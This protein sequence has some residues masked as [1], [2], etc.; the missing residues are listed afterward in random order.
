MPANIRF[1]NPTTVALAI[2]LLSVL[3]GRLAVAADPPTM[4]HGPMLGRPTSHSMAVWARTSQPG[5]FDVRFGTSADRLDQVVTAQATTRASDQTGWVT[6]SDLSPATRYWYQVYVAGRPQGH[7]GTF[8]TLPSAD[9]SKSCPRSSA[10]GR[11]ISSTSAGACRTR[12]WHRNVP[13]YFTFDDHELVNDI[14]GSGEAGKRHRRTRLSRHRHLCLARLPRLGEPDG[15]RPPDSFR[16]RAKL[17]AGSDLLVDPNTDFTKLPLAEMTNLHVHWG[18]PE[19]GV[20][21]IKYDN[22]AGNKNSYVYDIKE[23][24]DAA[25]PSPAHARPRPMMR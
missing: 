1:P 22:D 25:H 14:W 10:F 23:V 21:D 2:L 7:R 6:L 24:V 16:K 17:K 11:I 9:S 13:S 4:T 19:A 18:T 5:P 8:R 12:E 15:V 20:N 3:P